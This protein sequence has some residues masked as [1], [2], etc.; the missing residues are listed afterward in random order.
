M[1][2]QTNQ[3]KTKEKEMSGKDGDLLGVMSLLVRPHGNMHSYVPDLC[4]LVEL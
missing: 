2:Q 1:P 3:M 4:R